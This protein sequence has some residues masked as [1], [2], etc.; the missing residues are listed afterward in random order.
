MV[1]SGPMARTVE[2]VE[3]FLEQRGHAV[4]RL[5]EGTWL[6]RVGRDQAPAVVRVE[7]PVVLVEVNVGE[8]SFADSARALGFTRR[9]LE[10]NASG[11]V[12][13]AYGLVGERVVLTAALELAN[14]D[15]NEL[16]A[17]L[18]DVSLALTEHVPMLRQMVTVKE[19]G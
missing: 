6:V 19:G 4:E 7:P 10:L 11:L 12:H 1:G 17:V 16:G 18:S 3:R 14:L 5:S 9:L 15:E 13:A 8:V 2:D